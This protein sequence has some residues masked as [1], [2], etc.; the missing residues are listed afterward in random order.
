[1]TRVGIPLVELL[2]TSQQ[3]KRRNQM[4]TSN[5]IMLI[6]GTLGFLAFIVRMMTD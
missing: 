4:L 2:S 1:M 5:D 6:V 3:G